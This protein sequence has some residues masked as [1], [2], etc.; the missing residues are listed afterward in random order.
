MSNK[1][2]VK[3]R[4]EVARPEEQVRADKEA[5]CR[6]II[7]ADRAAKEK[8]LQEREERERARRERLRAELEGHGQDEGSQPAAKK[9]KK[10]KKQSCAPSGLSFDADDDG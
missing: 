9:Q 2:Y 1:D 3:K 8:E 5:A 7:N 4:E 6:A 10:K